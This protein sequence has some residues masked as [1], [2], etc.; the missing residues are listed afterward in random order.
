MSGLKN[1]FKEIFNLEAERSFFTPGRI[2]LIGEH[3]DYSGGNVFPTAI[4]FGTYAVVTKRNDKIVRLYSESFE[5]HGIVEVNLDTLVFDEKDDWANYPKGVLKMLLDA[6]YKLEKGFDAVFFGNIPNGAGLSSSASLEVLTGLIATTLNDV[7]IEM[8]DIVKLAQK[9]E[10]EFVGVQCGIMDQFAVGMAKKDSAMLL[11]TNTLEYS[12]VPV[13]LEDNI[14]VIMNTN[15]RRGLADSAYNERR[16][17]CETAL[18]LLQSVEH[19]DYLCDYSLDF[20]EENKSLITD[21]LVYKRAHHAITENERSLKAS[22]VLLENDL[23]SFGR[24]MNESHVSLR[25]DYDVTGIEL[26]TIV[27]AAWDHPATIGA[28]VTGAGFG[29]CAI[30]IVKQDSVDD[31]IESVQSTYSKTI[32]YKADFYVASIGQ[33]AHEIE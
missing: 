18:N 7:E 25:D 4:T 30:A 5:A 9:A 28:R 31:F 14:I 23:K 16:S 29:G 10:N 13:N 17:Q 24:L 32:G 22:S 33:G 12:Y 19:K 20:L 6:G 21:P 8:L 11:N 26:D 3:I 27:Q 15:K 2:N 1:R